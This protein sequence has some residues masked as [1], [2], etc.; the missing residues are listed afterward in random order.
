VKPY[1]R[2]GISNSGGG[3]DRQALGEAGGSSAALSW[4]EEARLMFRLDLSAIT[5]S[6]GHAVRIRPVTRDGD[7]ATVIE[8]WN[9]SAWVTGSDVVEWANGRPA[10]AE[11][12]AALGIPRQ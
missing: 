11:E 7:I 10:T 9:G 1:G 6:D 12:L 5:V 3:G 4:V 2:V 8:R